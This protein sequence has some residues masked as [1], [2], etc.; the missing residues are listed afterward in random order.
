MQTHPLQTS[1]PAT[2]PTPIRESSLRSE[3]H[4]QTTFA[5]LPV[6]ERGV[7]VEYLRHFTEQHFPDLSLDP[8]TDDVVEHVIKPATQ[9]RKVD[10]CVEIEVE[11]RNAQECTA[12]DT[13]VAGLPTKWLG[14]ATCFVS[15]AWKGRWRQLVA[16]LED[17]QYTR[18]KQGVH[19]PEYFWL[20]LF[21]INQ[22]FTAEGDVAEKLRRTVNAT[23]NVC[24]VFDR[25]EDPAMIK[26]CWCLYE[27]MH[28]IMC[29]A[30]LVVV[31]PASERRKLRRHITTSYHTIQETIRNIDARKAEAK[32]DTDKA[33]ILANIERDVPG[34]MAEL[35]SSVQR[36]INLWLAES[37]ELAL[38]A[39]QSP[40]NE[41]ELAAEKAFVI[42]VNRYPNFAT[43]LCHLMIVQDN[44]MGRITQKM[45]IL[46]PKRWVTRFMRA[47][48]DIIRYVFIAFIIIAPS[49]DSR[50]MHVLLGLVIAAFSCVV[51]FVPVMAQTT[52]EA[53]L[54]AVTMGA[55]EQRALGGDWDKAAQ[56]YAKVLDSPK[57][58]F[59]LDDMMIVRASMAVSMHWKE[60]Q[61]RG[62][63]KSGAHT[64][65]SWIRAL[66]D[67]VF[68]L[69]D[70]RRYS[71]KWWRV[72][73]KRFLDM[74]GF[75]PRA[76]LYLGG[77]KTRPAV[78]TDEAQRH[79][80]LGLAEIALGHGDEGLDKVAAGIES[81]FSPCFASTIMH[82]PFLAPLRHSPQFATRLDQLGERARQVEAHNQKCL[83]ILIPLLELLLMFVTYPWISPDIILHIFIWMLMLIFFSSS[84]IFNNGL[85]CWVFR[86]SLRI[87]QSAALR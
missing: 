1:Q 53:T 37:I 65:E 46:V 47:L 78:L 2:L 67:E 54:A 25:W 62:E 31:M 19:T 81:C 38:D 48:L 36:V 40:L 72:Q 63:L 11:F 28:C 33:M 51:M 45:P 70:A 22:H 3:V 4:R 59:V 39:M 9:A 41:E 61:R 12:V 18:T 10:Y 71:W 85:F 44:E 64:Q 75:V 83:D 57:W 29:N 5:F 27:I 30:R 79:Y 68:A 26:R 55:A 42:F 7:T 69:H 87:W 15:H 8:T 77:M 52:T 23:G 56:L 20:D 32:F 6:E 80:A 17:Y 16:A 84:L 82:S 60:M 49:H 21:A 73:F 35:N 24:L 74:E 13:I 14:K 76:M 86:N 66:C 34:G 43:R 50:R 58:N